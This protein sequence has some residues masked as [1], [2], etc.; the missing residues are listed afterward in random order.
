MNKEII[1]LFGYFMAA[2]GQAVL[3]IGLAFELVSY[4]EDHYPNTHSWPYIIWPSCVFMVAYSYFIIV[5]RI[6][7]ID[8]NIKR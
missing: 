1:M 6:I 5:R 3:L 7:Q 2:N 8:K 4:L